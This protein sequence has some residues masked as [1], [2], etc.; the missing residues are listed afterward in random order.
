[1]SSPG[2]IL[3]THTGSLPR[4]RP[5]RDALVA[6]DAGLPIDEAR[7]QKEVEAAVDEVVR[8]QRDAGVDVVNDG[9]QGKLSY[10]VYVKDRL[11]GF[12][13]ESR[14]LATG[15]P[16]DVAEHPVLA[17][18]WA[19]NSRGGASR[20]ACV[21]PVRVKDEDAVHRD[22]AALKAAA[23]DDTQHLFMSAASPGVIAFFF[24]NE[25]YSS[26]EAYVGA[27]AEAM[28]YEYRAIVDAGITLQVDCPDLAMARGADYADKPIEEFRRSLRTNV[29]ALNVALE[30]IPPER[31]RIHVCWGNYIGPHTHDVPLSELA[32]IMFEARVAGYSIESA[33]PRH[34]ADFA[35]FD[36]LS[37]P[38]GKYLIPGV[39]DSTTNYVEHPDLVAHRLVEYAKRIGRDNVMAGSD[40]GF[41]TGATSEMVVPSVVW[42]K[43]RAMADGAARASKVLWS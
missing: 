14:P 6:R 16:R 13:G 40:C 20:P 35:V 7:L 28:S 3:T 18:R 30:G 33:N 25:H 43:L 1:M 19:D 9:E 2:R 29:E 26:H 24:A 10:T 31:T 4:P 12:E 21:G 37:L 23:G 22:I 39:L 34:A 38:D 41:A 11:T 32:T 5:L 8:L 27:L 42:V 15:T 36:D 17:Q